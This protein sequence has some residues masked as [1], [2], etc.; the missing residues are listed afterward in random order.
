LQ[1]PDQETIDQIVRLSI[2]YGI[3]TPYTSYLVTEEMPLGAAEQERIAG[4]QYSQLQSAPLRP[5]LV[6]KL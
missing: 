5:C 6:R 4:E 1:G 3:V 2:R